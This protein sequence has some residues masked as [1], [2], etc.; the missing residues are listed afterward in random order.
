MNYIFCL[1]LML[2]PMLQLHQNLRAETHVF[3]YANTSN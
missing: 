2:H 1:I 3:A